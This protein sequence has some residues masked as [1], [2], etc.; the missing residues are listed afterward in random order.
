MFDEDGMEMK[1]KGGHAV[2]PSPD[3]CP[4]ER[5][6]GKLIWKYLTNLG[7]KTKRGKKMRHFQAFSVAG[8]SST[9]I[10]F[11]IN[12]WAD[13]IESAEREEIES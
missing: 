13:I 10:E 11:L 1:K 12:Q 9:K 4:H 2:S 6:G 7:L 3:V 8:R 5:S